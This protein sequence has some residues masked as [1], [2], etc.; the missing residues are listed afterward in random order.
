[1]NIEDA[2]LAAGDDRHARLED[3]PLRERARHGGAIVMVEQFEIALN[4]IGDRSCIG[5]P[6]IGG[7]GEV[8]RAVAAACPYRQ[9]NGGGE[10]AK[11]AGFFQ[12]LI[13]PDV[14]LGEFHPHAGQLANPDD[15]LPADGASHRFDG[16]AR[17][18]GEIEL[19][20]FTRLAQ[21][22]DGVIHR[23]RLLGKQPASERK[24]SL[25]IEMVRAVRHQQRHVA[26]DV[27]T[28]FA[29]GP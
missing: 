10:S 26:A 11:R 3:V 21:F 18:G 14:D 20:A 24:N 2:A 5:C 9:R 6:R 13:V 25:R 7:V 17:C 12:Q 28:I 1:M 27:R 23:E 15:G 16:A 29:G 8:E 19:E 4:R 22:V